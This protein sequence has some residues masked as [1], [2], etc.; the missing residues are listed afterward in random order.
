MRTVGFWLQLGGVDM[1]QGMVGEC[2]RCSGRV[3]HLKWQ[4]QAGRESRLVRA[5]P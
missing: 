5:R 1:V 4:G 2:S 3:D